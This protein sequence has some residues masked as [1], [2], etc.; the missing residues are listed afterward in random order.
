M[1]ATKK[2]K[3][4]V[5]LVTGNLKPSPE[6]KHDWNLFKTKAKLG[7][8]RKPLVNPV[9]IISTLDTPKCIKYDGQEIR[10]APRAKLVLG[11]K[12]LLVG[13]LPKGIFKKDMP[14][15]K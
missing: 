14:T 10:V 4:E 12:S 6:T 5:K 9:L 13:N 11:D 15:K 2:N 3:V 7:R 8:I 1:A